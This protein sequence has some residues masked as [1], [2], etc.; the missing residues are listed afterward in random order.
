MP[1]RERAAKKPKEPRPKLTRRRFLGLVG[2]SAGAL[3]L[4]GYGVLS[5]REK[6]SPPRIGFA[7]DSGNVRE[8]TFEAAPLN[9]ELGG[10]Q[11]STWG[12]NGVV[13]GPEIRVTEGDTLRVN[14]QNRLPSD[15][16]IHWHGLPVPNA[17]DGFAPL[18]QDPIAPGEDFVYEFVV[19]TAGSYIYHSHVGIQQDRGLYGALIVEPKEEELGYD[20]EYVL[21]LDDWLDG[22][23]GTPED[24]LQELQSSGGGGMD[25]GMMG[26]RGGGMM[27][28]STID[29]PYY[30]INGRTVNDPETLNVR[31][32]ERVRLRI[33]NPAGE[34]IFRFA[35][36]GH[37][38]TVTHADGSPV[39][40]VEVDA[41]RIGMGE[42]YDVLL[43][44]DNPGIW[45]VAASPEGKSGLSRVL[46]RYEE[47][48]QSSPPPADDTP[49]ELGGRLLTYWDLRAKGLESLSG[50]PDRTHRL[51]LSGGMG[52][53]AWTINGQ[54]YP[55]A[56]PLEVR[57]G[58]RVRFEMQNR[59]M[60]VHPMHLHGHFFQIETGTGHGP[61]KDTVMVEPRMGLMTLDFVADNPG[62]WFFH[63]H[64]L[65]HMESGMARV[66]S[67]GG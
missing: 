62:E 32:G 17:M 34:S 26:G 27:R 24:T 44:A 16:T 7:V 46:L 37:K 55:D 18:T 45:Q 29:Y 9:F 11:V 65:Y 19:P 50:S 39:E 64:N 57:E 5:T 53:Y 8:Y 56:D 25:G 1:I 30:L 20:R 35:V 14:V 59:S 48:N 15:T 2:L 58:E 6:E 66:V 40:P 42:R 67:Y 49:D 12:Y 33:L 23:S 13:P 36:A 63:C 54:R 41:L 43:E 28:G 52:T 61:F 51:T 4:G 21:Q 3:V 10:R 22:V 47:S 60:M 38:L 31:R